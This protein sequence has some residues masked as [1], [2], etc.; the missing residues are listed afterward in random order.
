MQIFLMK[1]MAASKPYWF[2][3]HYGLFILRV[4]KC[5]YIST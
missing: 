1:E 2:K 4:Y 5:V 3:K